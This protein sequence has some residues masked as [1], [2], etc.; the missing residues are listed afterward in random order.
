MPIIVIRKLLSVNCFCITFILVASFYQVESVPAYQ[1]AT[2]SDNSTTNQAAAPI[3]PPQRSAETTVTNNNAEPPADKIKRAEWIQ[4]FINAF[5]AL[6]VLWQAWTYYKQR[7]IMEQQTENAR[8]SE[9]AY[10]GVK[11]VVTQNFVIG[12]E[13]VIR[14]TILNGGR[15]PA[16]RVKV[17]VNLRL[18]ADDLPPECPVLGNVVSPTFLPAGLEATFSY[19]FTFILT[20][21]WKTAI[22]NGTR[23]VF[24]SGEVHYDDCWGNKLAFPFRFVYSSKDGIWKDYRDP[25]DVKP[26]VTVTP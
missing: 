19:P 17:P 22:E 23:K 18:T 13:P 9:R 11:T 7:Q 8:I 14:V 4:I 24:L 12:Q 5:V 6:V 10:I 26:R 20:P 21:T 1:P 25:E 16:Y 3:Q 15:T 2:Q